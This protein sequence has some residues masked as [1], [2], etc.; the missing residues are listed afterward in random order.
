MNNPE[1]MPPRSVA[2][3]IV[4][5]LVAETKAARRRRMRRQAFWSRNGAVI[6][7]GAAW[8]AFM[9]ILFAAYTLV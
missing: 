8:L 9:A 5:E 2:S 7:V 1:D 4:A 3:V 6:I